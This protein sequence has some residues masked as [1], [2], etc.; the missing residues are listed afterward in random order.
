MP[1]EDP[2]CDTPQDWRTMGSPG[3]MIRQLRPPPWS[4]IRSS[5]SWAA[6]LPI[7]SAG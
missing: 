5:R 4:A 2:F 1:D 3:M 6:T 7:V